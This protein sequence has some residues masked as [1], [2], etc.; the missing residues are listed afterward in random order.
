MLIY[1]LVLDDINNDCISQG[2][3]KNIKFNFFIKILKK[4]ELFFI[5][6]EYVIFYELD[7]TTIHGMNNNVHKSKKWIKHFSEYSEVV[8]DNFYM[9]S[10]YK[11]LKNLYKN[12][13]YSFYFL[14]RYNK[15][16]KLKKNFWKSL[17][18]YKIFTLHHKLKKL[19]ITVK[20][21]S[22]LLLSLSSGISAKQLGMEEKKNKK[23]FKVFSI[24]LKSVFKKFKSTNNIFKC[25]VQFK[26]LSFFL[27]KYTQYLSQFKFK[28]VCF[29]HT[30]STSNQFRFKKIRS[31]KK[32]F[33]KN[34]LV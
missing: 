10:F 11:I 27:K 30:P 7:I 20:V 13:I 16:I 23:S 19:N 25:I 31:L 8:L 6:E 17:H 1:W 21:D 28:E 5:E 22:Q 4:N 15:S 18:F 26:G 32:N 34:F 3:L 29:I 33:R 9:L 2:K 14:K 24:M 12:Y